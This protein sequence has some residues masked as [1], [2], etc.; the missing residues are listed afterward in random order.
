M[1]RMTQRQLDEFMD[2]PDHNGTMIL[3]IARPERGPLSVPL[4]F[5]WDGSSIRFSTKRSRRHTMAF[6]A[7]GRATAMIHHEEYG[8]GV[9]VER[10]VAVE[11]PVTIPAGAQG[12]PDVF[13]EAVLT[14]ESVVGVIY[15][16]SD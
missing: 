12:D 2:G 7:A 5:R 15:D 11:G 13:V 3:S 14:A 6:L 9:Q 10:Y 4:S 16:F 1:A 8:S